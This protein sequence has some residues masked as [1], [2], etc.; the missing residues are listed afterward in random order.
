M[1][2]EFKTLSPKYSSTG[3]L[4][5]DNI[6]KLS[7]QYAQL[8]A[9][10]HD[11]IKYIWEY[12]ESLRKERLQTEERYAEIRKRLINSGLSSDVVDEQMDRLRED[13]DQSFAMSQKIINTFYLEQSGG[14]KEKCKEMFLYGGD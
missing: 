5:S 11:K 13:M 1:I 2:N 9:K 8:I 14:F 7:E 4:Q 10:Y 12:E 3:N 6:L